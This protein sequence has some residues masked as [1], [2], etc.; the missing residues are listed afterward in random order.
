M[1]S[2]TFKT[3]AMT[4]ICSACPASPTFERPGIKGRNASRWGLPAD[5]RHVQLMHCFV[6]CTTVNSFCEDE[7]EFS[8][9][10][11][12][13][14]RLHLGRWNARSMSALSLPMNTDQHDMS[15]SQYHCV[16]NVAK[17]CWVTSSVSSQTSGQPFYGWDGKQRGKGW[18]G[19]LPYYVYYGSLTWKKICQCGSFFLFIHNFLFYMS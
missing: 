4:F 2:R 17:G 3:D 15:L 5:D 11:G 8:A 14:C 13:E 1:Y 16:C 6:L 7:R 12:A 19:V 18:P 10:A 9:C